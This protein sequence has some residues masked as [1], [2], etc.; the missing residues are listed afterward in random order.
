MNG[1]LEYDSIKYTVVCLQRRQGT[2]AIKDKKNKGSYH[3]CW[4]LFSSGVDEEKMNTLEHPYWDIKGKHCLFVFRGNTFDIWM[5]FIVVITFKSRRYGIWR[6]GPSNRS[7]TP[8]GQ[9]EQQ[10]CGREKELQFMLE[11][12]Y[13]QGSI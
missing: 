9:N 10:R 8:L 5:H 7:A 3:D 4:V 6:R 11:R 12:C 13:T 2:F 1:K